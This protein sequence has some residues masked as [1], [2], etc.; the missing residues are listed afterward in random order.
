MVWQPLPGGEVGAILGGWTWLEAKSEQ[1]CPPC[2]AMEKQSETH[3][4]TGMKPAF[5]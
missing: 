4:L 1:K 2:F 5:E 3:P